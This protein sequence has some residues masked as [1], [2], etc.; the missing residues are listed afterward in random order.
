MVRQI[1]SATAAVSALIAVTVAF[2][3]EVAGPVLLAMAVVVAIAGR[4]DAV[5]RWAAVGFG[6]IGGGLYSPMRRV[7]R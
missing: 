6:V 3:G 5:V 1:W 4:R 7:A 2:D